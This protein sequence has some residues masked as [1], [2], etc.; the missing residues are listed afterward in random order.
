MKES[1]FYYSSR[2]IPDE[3][4]VDEKSIDIDVNLSKEEKKHIQIEKI[5]RNSYAN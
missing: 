4:N 2:K 3:W 1:F 5:K